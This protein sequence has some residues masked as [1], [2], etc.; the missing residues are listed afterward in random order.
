MAGVLIEAYCL[1]YC[2]QDGLRKEARI[3]VWIDYPQQEESDRAS[4]A[5]KAISVCR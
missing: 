1:A 5:P 3:R 4:Q 2:L